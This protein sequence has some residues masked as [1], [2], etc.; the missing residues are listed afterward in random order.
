MEHDRQKKAP[1]E[2]RIALQ[3]SVF[4]T[5]HSISQNQPDSLKNI[6]LKA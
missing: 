3:K 4:Q 1:L 6:R 5:C 2:N